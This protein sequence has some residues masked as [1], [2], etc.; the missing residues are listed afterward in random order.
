LKK[1]ATTFL[2]RSAQRHSAVQAYIAPAIT[3][4]I[5]PDAG[6][7]G[8]ARTHLPDTANEQRRRCAVTTTS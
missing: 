6:V 2:K 5:D 7:R 4:W 1:T 3:K 8:E